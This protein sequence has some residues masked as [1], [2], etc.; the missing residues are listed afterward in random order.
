MSRPRGPVPA[1]GTNDRYQWDMRNGADP[2]EAC[3]EA[4]ARDQATY[5][6]ARKVPANQVRAEYV[7]APKPAQR[8]HVAPAMVR[9]WGPEQRGRIRAILLEL[10]PVGEPRAVLASPEARVIALID[11]AQREERR[12][13][14]AT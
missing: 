9:E 14:C 6:E 10:M 2:C 4:H 7:R 12:S 13:A 11:R 8:D 3:K 1:H 5:R